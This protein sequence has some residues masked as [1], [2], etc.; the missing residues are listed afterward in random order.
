MSTGSGKDLNKSEAVENLWAAALSGTLPAT[1][2]SSLRSRYEETAGGVPFPSVVSWL[3]ALAA[4]FPLPV[5]SATRTPPS[6]NGDVDA[7]LGDGSSVTFEVKAQVKKPSFADI[8]QSDWIRDQTDLLSRLVATSSAIASH[9]AG[10]GANSLAS[11]NVD[12][13]WSDASLHL[14]DLSAITDA[15]A[16]RQMRVNSSADL[17]TFIDRKWFLH[18]TQQGARLC[19]LGE[20]AP[21]RHLLT[22]GSPNWQTKVNQKG[23]ALQSLAPGGETWFTYHLYPNATLK[24]RHKMHSAAFDGVTWI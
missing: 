21:I 4:R 3:Q 18:V 12:P 22:G 8:T 15:G 2:E 14:A 13:K 17:T 10:V 6:I 11:V 20:L 9:F 16:R 7:T 24:G 19:R 1:L 5:T 23:R